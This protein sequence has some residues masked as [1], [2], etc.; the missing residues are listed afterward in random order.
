MAATHSCFSADAGFLTSL[1]RVDSAAVRTAYANAVAVDRAPRTQKEWGDLVTGRFAGGA[2]DA[3]ILHWATLEGMDLRKARPSGRMI[4]GIRARP[5]RRRNGCIDRGEWREMRLR[6]LCSRGDKQYHGNRHFRLSPDARSCTFQMYGHKLRLDPANMSGNA[7]EILCHAAKLAA[8]KKINLTFRIDAKK[9]ASRSDCRRQWAPL[10]SFGRASRLYMGFQF[11]CLPTQSG[12]MWLVFS[13]YRHVG[14]E[15]GP[16]I[17][18]D[19][20]TGLPNV[21]VRRVACQRF[22]PTTFSR[23]E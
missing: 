13:G 6:P 17:L 3:W 2:G 4:F 11:C 18:S 9:L 8:D 20:P 5:D 15:P 12:Y 23:D 21:N 14:V 1:R 16:H 19:S 10:S 7:G 22:G